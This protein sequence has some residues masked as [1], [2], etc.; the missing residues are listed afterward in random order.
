M[1]RYNLRSPESADA[2]LADQLCELCGPGADEYSLRLEICEDVCF[3]RDEWVSAGEVTLHP[4]PPGASQDRGDSIIAVRQAIR[5]GFF[6][7]TLPTQKCLEQGLVDA[8]NNSPAR[9]PA[10]NLKNEWRIREAAKAVA[11][12]AHRCGLAHPMIDA[13]ALS[14]MPFRNPVSVVAD[15]SAVLQGGLDFVALHLA[16]AAR[17]TIPAVVHMEILN[18][19]DRYFSQRRARKPSAQMLMDHVLSQA[20]QRVLLRLERDH[21][22]ERSRLGADP[23]RGIVQP[24]SDAEDKSLGLQRVQRSFADRLILE[25]AIQ[26]RNRVDP[27]HP[28]MLMTADQGQA[29]MA[30]AEGIE[31]MFFDA[32]GVSHLFGTTLSGV[33]FR[34]FADRPRTR[35]VALTRVLWELAVTFGRARA[36]NVGTEAGLEVA[37]IGPALSWQ[38]YH[39]EDDLLWTAASGT[40]PPQAPAPTPID[41]VTGDTDLSISPPSTPA[42]KARSAGSY[43]FSPHSML[44]LMVVVDSA[45]VSDDDALSVVGVR[46]IQT[47]EQYFRFL[48]AGDFATRRANGLVGTERLTDLLQSMATSAFDDMQRLLAGVASF[49]GFLS[50]LNVG[51]PL[52]REESGLRKVAYAPYCALAEACCAGAFLAGFGIFATP[53][54][55]PPDQFAAQAV[56]AYDEV[57][58][59]EDFALTGAWLEHLVRHTGIHPIRARQRLAEAQQGGYVHRFVEGS[60]PET[61]YENRA[62]H[63]LHVEGRV[64]GL[65]RINLYHGDFLI[66]GRAAGSIRLGGVR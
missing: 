14:R 28:V 61:R 60:T 59:G 23:L 3:R 34:P 7:W 41:A 18:L 52:A 32:S 45:P 19:I 48:L 62:L 54:N 55:P 43:S 49:E 47:Y 24:D 44:K 56:Q 37:A 6:D 10:D 16:P 8:M 17:I 51:T 53:R 46:S 12:V 30:L 21:Q 39:S 66:P 35:A 4:A 20:G 29:R 31:P 64:P 9:P 26:R 42:V 2:L 58:E 22:L 5:Y 38:P 50:R 25:T 11:H 15:T 57:R 36:I 63:V 1:S 27:N 40:P 33:T 65:R 13:M